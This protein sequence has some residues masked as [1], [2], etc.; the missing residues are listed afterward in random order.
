MKSP[1]DQGPTDPAPVESTAD[2]ATT[3][4]PGL[5]T[6][7]SVYCFVLGAFVCYVAVLAVF[8]AMFSR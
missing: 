7:K 6:W 8:T 2:E 1:E 5:R 4:L 3:G